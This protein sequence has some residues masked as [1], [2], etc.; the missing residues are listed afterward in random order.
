MEHN[1]QKP[2]ITC[3]YAP[4]VESQLQEEW[5]LLT[6]DIY[7]FYPLLIKYVDQHRNYWLKNDIPEAEDVY[8]RVAQIFHIWSN[9]QVIYF[10]LS[11]CLSLIAS[12][13]WSCFVSVSLDKDGHNSDGGFPYLVLQVV[14]LCLSICRYLLCYLSL[15][16]NSLS[17]FIVQYFRR[18]E[19]NYISLN[20]I[21]NT[22]LVMPTASSRN[23]VTTGP[24]PVSS[25]GGKVKVG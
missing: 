1:S 4:Q 3:C 19:T 18:E 14:A 22:T 17:F 2:K 12:Y 16:V 25:G 10:S 13:P 21:D 9:S 7:L 5:Q 20:E 11:V 8:N 23:R 15:S 24:D 6:R